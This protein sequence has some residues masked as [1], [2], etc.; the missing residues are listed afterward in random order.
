MKGKKK[1]RERE[2]DL[3]GFGFGPP[4]LLRRTCMCVCARVM[5]MPLIGGGF[6]FAGTL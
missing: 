4:S 1:E 2:R 3:I 5:Y 6:D